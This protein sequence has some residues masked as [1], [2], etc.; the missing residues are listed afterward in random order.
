[1]NLSGAFRAVSFA[2][3]PGWYDDNVSAALRAFRRSARRSTQ[4]PY[5][6][7]A[8][9]IRSEFFETAFA[10]AEKIP[11]TPSDAEAR[12]FFERHFQPCFINPDN[13][14]QGFV[15]GYYEPE[16]PASREPS[17]RFTVPLHARPDDLVSVNESNRPGHLD[18]ELRFA[19]LSDDGLVAY[20]DREAIDR[21]A[22]KS[23]GLE[24]CWLADPVDAFFVHIQGAARLH[25]QDGGAIRVTY[26]A[27]N[28]Y[29][30]TAIGRVLAESGE[31]APADV[32]MQSIRAWLASH[33]ACVN[34]ILWKNRSYI[35][36]RE[37]PLGDLNLGPIAAAKVQL[38]PMRSIAVDRILHCFGTP[39]YVDAPG[40]HE[41]VRSPFR[42]LM[43]AQD[44]GSAIRGAARGD[45]FI[46]TGDAAGRAAGSIRH[47]AD[48]Y[49]LL[50]R[51][52]WEARK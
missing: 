39:I 20:F 12:A 23:R 2:E 45:I 6:D 24:L 10:E 35:F 36:F 31:I 9:G 33:P 30:F 3:L 21:G 14:A 16:L 38:E 49:A 41:V 50:P 4:K 28:G 37:T 48:F 52:L 19:R 25:M 26:A 11:N 17:D 18:P 42:R 29:P 1:M 44:T 47:S 32:T 8:L 15:T 22:L 43:I 7:G 46:G 40:L 13:D 27:K 34:M 51:F 5:R